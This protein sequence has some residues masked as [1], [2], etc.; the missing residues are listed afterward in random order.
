MLCRLEREHRFTVEFS[1]GRGGGGLRP[2]EA[3]D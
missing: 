2:N 1:G 3:K